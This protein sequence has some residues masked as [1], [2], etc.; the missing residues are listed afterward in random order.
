MKFCDKLQKIRKENNVTQEQL[1]DKLNVSRQAVSKW[2][3]GTAYPDTEKLIQISKIFNTSL[4]ELINDSKDNNK[5]VNNKKFNFME[6][7]NIIFDFINKSVNM[8]WS[9]TFGEKLKFLFEMAILVLAIIAAAI[10]SKDVI[11]DIIRRIFSFMPSNILRFITSTIDTLIYTLWIILG[12]IIFVRVFKTRYLDYYIVISD[13]SVKE[14]VIEEPIKELKERKEYKI[15][16][17]DPEHSSFNLLKKIGNVFIFC[18]K[19]LGIFLAL[20]AVMTFIFLMILF[21]ISLGYLFYGLFFNGIT[22]ALL[23]MIAFTLLVI[24]FIYNLLF[25]QKNAYQRMFMVF[26]ISISLIGIGFGLSFASLRNFEIVNDSENGAL[27]EGQIVTISMQDNLIVPGLVNVSEDKI[28][29]SDEYEDI[30][31]EARTINNFKIDTYVYHH[32]DEDNYNYKIVDMYT[33]YDSIKSFNKVL[34]DFKNKKINTYILHDDGDNYVIDKVY[35]SSDNLTQ[36]KENYE[37]AF[38]E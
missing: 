20:P 16:I 24:W 3:S 35:I 32:Y 10:I 18:L 8:F 28:V 27:G 14:K 19:I 38:E 4:D 12:C 22:L 31:I 2:E 5:V 9:M 36:I 15:V 34:D 26:I 25:N 23:G 30:K 21:V 13:D 37:N 29:T 7:F 17:R 6:T 33:N 11:V 1:A